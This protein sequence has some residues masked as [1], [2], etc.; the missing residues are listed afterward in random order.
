MKKVLTFL[1]SVTGFVFIAA[2]IYMK[3]ESHSVIA[4]GRPFATAQFVNGQWAMPLE[5]FAK[6]G[7]SSVTLEPNF[8][9]QGNELFGLLLPAVQKVQKEKIK[10]E[11]SAM[12]DTFT[13][14]LKVSP[15]EQK[16]LGGGLFHVRKA[17]L[18]S[19][20]IF[21]ADGKAWIPMKDVASALGGTF[22]VP[23]G[24]LQ[25]GQSLSI[26]FTLNGNGALA[27]NQ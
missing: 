23:A 17:G 14:N 4:N 7:G 15:A 5:D 3:I 2:P 16:A 24:N 25:P 9:L 12:P 22:T 20:G 11:A 19:R 21:M 10:I 8:R 6:L 1:L 13:S 27:F 26:N 18:I